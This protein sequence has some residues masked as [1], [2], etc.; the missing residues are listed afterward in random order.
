MISIRRLLL[1]LVVVLIGGGF[2]CRAQKLENDLFYFENP[3]SLYTAVSGLLSSSQEKYS[4]VVGKKDN[5]FPM[6][7]YTKRYNP[8]GDKIRVEKGAEP[9][10]DYYFGHRSKVYIV[11]WRGKE[12]RPE[13]MKRFYQEHWNALRSKTNLEVNGR[14][15]LTPGTFEMQEKVTFMGDTE[16]LHRVTVM[17]LSQTLIAM[18]FPPIDFYYDLYQYYD[19]KADATVAALFY[20]VEINPDMREDFPGEKSDAMRADF[21]KHF[22]LKMNAPVYGDSLSFARPPIFE[23][24]EGGEKKKPEKKNENDTIPVEQPA[25]DNHVIIGCK[26]GSGGAPVLRRS[27][28]T[29]TSMPVSSFEVLQFAEDGCSVYI[30]YKY[31]SLLAIDKE[32]GTWRKVVE[33]PALSGVAVDAAGRLLLYTHRGLVRW[34]GKSI[35]TS[36]V[37][38]KYPA[39]AGNGYK[40]KV[41][42]TTEGDLL[43]YG[44]S[45]SPTVRLSEDGKLLGSSDKL[46]GEQVLTTSGGMVWARTMSKIV[47][48][49]FSGTP[50]EHSYG[51]KWSNH[52]SGLSDMCLRGDDLF[53]CGSKLLICQN[54]KWELL[55]DPKSYFLSFMAID[56]EGT[57][58]LAY[59]DGLMRMGPDGKK[60][61]QMLTS[62]AA[63]EG[64]KDLG[65]IKGLYVDASGN[66]W[67]VTT[68]DVIAYNPAGLVGLVH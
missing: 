5:S 27:S 29:V 47:S 65:Y 16:A 61:V 52:L 46:E 37:I 34:N 18:L 63:P 20:R 1:V 44:G 21:E 30:L 14:A 19:Q 45:S 31:G 68:K 2:S 28:G 56:A 60:P 42:R 25:A 24:R 15:V 26:G 8:I 48:G 3:Q 51:D 6:E 11:A 64:K 50:V 33:D 35:D 49:D 36:P 4:M 32:N 58:W 10:L 39:N 13:F 17:Q 67:I 12:K 22:K 55:Y 53:A 40:S 54:G 23:V 57:I 43:V 7:E 38:F 66:L 41:S 62:L 9:M 59:N